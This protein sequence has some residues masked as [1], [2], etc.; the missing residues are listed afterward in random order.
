ME[1]YLYRGP[2]YLRLK[3]Q[4]DDSFKI[5][6]NIE[7]TILEINKDTMECYLVR[8]EQEKLRCRTKLKFVQ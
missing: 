3:K 2:G 4:M 7:N 1:Q 8:Q 5:G 6:A